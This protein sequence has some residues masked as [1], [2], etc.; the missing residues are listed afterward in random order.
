MQKFTFLVDFRRGRFGVHVE[1]SVGRGILFDKCI[2]N[3][4]CYNHHGAYG[5][6][7]GQSLDGQHAVPRPG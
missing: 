5:H 6:H 7:R 1:Q 2:I 3:G 4:C